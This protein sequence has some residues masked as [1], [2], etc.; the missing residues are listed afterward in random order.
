MTTGHAMKKTTAASVQQLPSR[1]E[2]P[3]EEQEQ[4]RRPDRREC[5]HHLAD[6]L[7]MVEPEQLADLD[8]DA[9]TA[10]NPGG[11]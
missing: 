2:Q 11:V 3:D 7:R 5:V 6:A 1:P 8:R 4:Q 9:A 10:K